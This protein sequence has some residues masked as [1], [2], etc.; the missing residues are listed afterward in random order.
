MSI[1]PPSWR[2][3]IGGSPV[4]GGPATPLRKMRN[5]PLRSGTSRAPSG[6]IS[7]SQGLVSPS[8]TVSTRN[9]CCSEVTTPVG[10]GGGPL[11]DSGDAAARARNSRM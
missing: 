5:C 3:Q 1:R 11:R 9:A 2:T 6:R 8:I 7:T 10:S 4:I